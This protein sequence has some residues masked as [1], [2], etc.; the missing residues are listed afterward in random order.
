MGEPLRARIL[1]L[2]GGLDPARLAHLL[3]RS[4]GGSR[5]ALCFHRAGAVRR[6]GELLPKLTSPAAEIDALIEFLLRAAGRTDPW[7][8]VAFDDGYREAAEYVLDRA[9]LFP[10][11][12]WLFFVCPQKTE[13]GVGFRWDL[14]EV[15]RRADASFDADAELEAP[16]DLSAENLRDDL[17]EVASLPEFALADVETCRAIQRLP[18]AALGNHSNVHCRAASLTPEQF[19]REMAESFADFARL[20]GPARHFAFPF[21]VPGV[22]FGPAHVAALR[23]LGSFQIWSTEPRPY[24]PVERARGAVLPRFAVDG[25]RTFRASAAHVAL[26]ALRPRTGRGRYP[27]AAE[28]AP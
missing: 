10:R 25:S 12:E 24:R 28:A 13:R 5:L 19:R 9:P 3:R 22:D 20:F 21:G 1:T 27:P 7:L 8:T 23:E 4:V 18:N 16:V 6:E 2:V 26:H 17:R 15:R 14:A 11:V